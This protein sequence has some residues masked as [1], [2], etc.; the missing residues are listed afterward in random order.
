MLLAATCLLVQEPTSAAV[1]G[2]VTKVRA[3]A[4]KIYGELFANAQYRLTVL[5]YVAQTFALGG[6]T[7]WAA[8]L[9]ERR[10]CLPLAT[11]NQRFGYVTVITGL[12][13]TAVGGALP[14]RIGGSDR[15]RAALAVCGWSSFVAAPLAFA[16]LFMPDATWAFVAMGVCE[17][18]IFASVAPTNSAVLS[19]VPIALRANAMAA[20]IFAIHLFGDLISS[21]IIGSVSDAYHDSKDA[22]SG[23]AGLRA[24][25]LLLP[26]ALALSAAFWIMGS[27]T[28]AATTQSPR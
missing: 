12:V 22:C 3:S 25:M 18:A 5:G 17:L 28:P 24:G 8:P 21:P 4:R 20:S 26:V 19:S 9:F 2:G 14:D 7:A 16:V 10:L 6:F 11:G 27:R 1:A 13:G 23:G 15:T